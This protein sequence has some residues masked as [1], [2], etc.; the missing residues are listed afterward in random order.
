MNEM[1]EVLVRITSVGFQTRYKSSMLGVEVDDDGL[2][3]DDKKLFLISTNRKLLP[4]EPAYGQIWK[5]RGY[6]S[7]RKV[8]K[9]SYVSYEIRISAESM[10]FILPE[11]GE[12]FIRFVADQREFVGIGERK[13]RGL[14]KALGSSIFNDVKE[15]RFETFRPYLSETSITALSM[16]SKSLKHLSTPNFLQSIAS[17]KA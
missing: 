3:K 5:V 13:A 17:R 4:V 6:S 14:W 10:E 12:A 16:G 9:K 1:I 11:T 2:R 15:R 7:V 8:D